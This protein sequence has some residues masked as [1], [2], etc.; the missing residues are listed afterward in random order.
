MPVI[1]T[2]HIQ[3]AH[4]L[5]ADAEIDLYKLTAVGGGIIRF[6][7]DNPLTWLGNEYTGLPLEFTGESF[8]SEGSMAQPQ[9]M[10]GQPDVDLSIFKGLIYDGTIDGAKIEKYT[11]LLDNIIANVDTKVTRTYR[12]KRIDNYSASS[13]VLVLAAFSVAGPSTLPFRQFIPPAFPF[14]RI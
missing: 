13:I 3:D 12:V 6:K 11:V 2:S 10:I 7:A 5:T 9:L 4:K 8:N 14:V 1:P